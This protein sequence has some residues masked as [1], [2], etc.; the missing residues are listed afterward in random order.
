MKAQTLSEGVDTVIRSC[1]HKE[2]DSH[3]NHVLSVGLFL[4]SGRDSE[5]E[6][7]QADSQELCRSSLHERKGGVQESSYNN[8]SKEGTLSFVW[9]HLLYCNR[10]YNEVK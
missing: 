8:P 4:T 1:E 10:Q 2:N 6:S 9:G 3:L 7:R 5:L